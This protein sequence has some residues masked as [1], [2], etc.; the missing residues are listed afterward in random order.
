VIEE[1]EKF[2]KVTFGKNIA[3]K[4]KRDDEIKWHNWQKNI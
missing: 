1:F 3:K 2:E 4:R